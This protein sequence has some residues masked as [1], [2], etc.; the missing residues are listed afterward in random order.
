MQ[1]S[2]ITN[3]IDRIKYNLHE[4]FEEINANYDGNTEEFNKKYSEAYDTFFREINT[5]FPEP[6]DENIKRKLSELN[7]FIEKLKN[8]ESTLDYD[9]DGLIEDLKKLYRS[10]APASQLKSF[11]SSSS[12]PTR[13]EP[14]IEP[15]ESLEHK[16]NRVVSPSSS[17]NNSP[18]NIALAH[19]KQLNLLASER[20]PITENDARDYVKIG[21]KLVNIIGRERVFHDGAIALYRQNVQKYVLS[22]NLRD[23]S[24]SNAIVQST[25]SARQQEVTV[26]NPSNINYQL[27]SV[28]IPNTFPAIA[29]IG[30]SSNTSG[31]LMHNALKNATSHERK[32]I[33][34]AIRE[35]KR[36]YDGISKSLKPNDDVRGSILDFFKNNH[37]INADDYPVGQEFSRIATI[38]AALNDNIVSYVMSPNSK[39][40]EK[41]VDPF[42]RTAKTKTQDQRRLSDNLLNGKQNMTKEIFSPNKFAQVMSSKLPEELANEY[43]QYIQTIFPYISNEMKDVLNYLTFEYYAANPRRDKASKK[44][45]AKNIKSIINCLIE[46]ER[47]DTAIQIKS[48]I[49]ENAGLKRIFDSIASLLEGK[50][51]YDFNYTTVLSEFGKIV[52]DS[53]IL[54]RSIAANGSLNAAE[55]LDEDIQIIEEQKKHLI[56]IDFLSLLQEVAKELIK[57]S[58]K[59]EDIFNSKKQQLS[60]QI[61][62][63]SDRLNYD[64]QFTKLQTNKMIENYLNE[65]GGKIIELEC[66]NFE[67]QVLARKIEIYNEM[68]EGRAPSK[69]IKKLCEDSKQNLSD[70]IRRLESKKHQLMNDLS[71]ASA[72]LI[73]KVLK[74]PNEAEFDKLASELKIDLSE[75]VGTKNL[76]NDIFSSLF[77][78]TFDML[79]AGFNM[80]FENLKKGWGHTTRLGRAGLVG[81]GTA[82]VT[83]AFNPVAIGAGF[84]AGVGAQLATDTA[85]AAVEAARTRFQN[86]TVGELTNKYQ[87]DGYKLNAAIIALFE[88]RTRAEV[89]NTF[90]VQTLF[91]LESQLRGMSEVE[92]NKPENEILIEL[93]ERLEANYQSLKSG[94]DLTHETADKLFRSD[95]TQLL[96]QEYQWHAQNNTQ[97]IAETLARDSKIKEFVIQNPNSGLMLLSHSAVTPAI[98]YSQSAGEAVVSREIDSDLLEPEPSTAITLRS[99][100]SASPS[101]AIIPT[102]SARSLVL[103]YNSNESN[104]P[105]ERRARAELLSLDAKCEQTNQRIKETRS[106][107]NNYSDMLRL[108]DDPNINSIHTIEPDLYHRVVFDPTN[109][110][111]EYHI[112]NKSGFSG[113]SGLIYW[114]R[115][116]LFFFGNTKSKDELRSEASARLSVADGR[117]VWHLLADKGDNGCELFYTILAAQN[118]ATVATRR[119]N[120]ADYFDPNVEYQGMNPIAYALK[121]GNYNL[122]KAL[123]EQ[124][125]TCADYF[126]SDE[127]ERCFQNIIKSITDDDPLAKAEFKAISGELIGTQSA[128]ASWT[129]RLAP[130]AASFVSSSASPNT[131]SIQVMGALALYIG[132]NAKLPDDEAKI[133][134]FIN[135][136]RNPHSA[137]IHIDGIPAE[138]IRERAKSINNA[139]LQKTH[140]TRYLTATKALQGLSHIKQALIEADLSYEQQRIIVALI[141]NDIDEV[142]KI[143]DDP[144]TKY[145][146]STVIEL[147]A[148]GKINLLYLAAKLDRPE[149]AAKLYECGTPV[150]LCGPDELDTSK[151]VSALILAAREGNSQVVTDIL[152]STIKFNAAGYK[153][154]TVDSQGR[155]A[156]HYLAENKVDPTACLKWVQSEIYYKAKFKNFPKFCNIADNQSNTP[157]HLLVETGNID[158]IIEIDKWMREQKYPD[159]IAAIFSRPTNA[160]I[161]KN[162]QGLTPIEIALKNDDVKTF[163]FLL[164]LMIQTEHYKL[165][166][167]DIIDK[168]MEMDPESIQPF[169]KCYNEM[170]TE[171]LVKGYEIDD[172]NYLE[173]LT[174][175]TS[176]LHVTTSTNDEST[177]IPLLA[178]LDSLYEKSRGWYT[179]KGAVY[180]TLNENILYGL[181]NTKSPRL[182]EEILKEAVKMGGDFAMTVLVSLY[183]EATKGNRIACINFNRALQ[184]MQANKAIT[185]TMLEKHKIPN[186]LLEV[187]PEPGQ[188]ER[189]RSSLLLSN[190]LERESGTAASSSPSSPTSS[191]ERR[192]PSSG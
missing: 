42:V 49:N 7:D 101:Y 75:K 185:L 119:W 179:S 128:L 169:I 131:K 32:I 87:G 157:M 93:Q 127:I 68:L 6:H 34:D 102:S 103:A 144:K 166:E 44:A 136:V 148:F 5:C 47:Q 165:V 89:V 83:G 17:S 192:G 172:K 41:L 79:S 142:N 57:S 63:I 20:E 115:E 67:L 28:A 170:A 21:D 40:Y 145:I 140:L 178:C 82:A 181:L 81:A 147:K 59:K 39:E 26:F 60:N 116:K 64:K 13:V 61:E 12:G 15:L 114:F 72:N 100:T 113:D 117:S 123:M 104:S 25:P 163:D 92:R 129:S 171:A 118:D 154:R 35:T 130:R 73:K 177:A 182:C 159:G 77:T 186:A 106:R 162:H 160:F 105:E 109:M 125:L 78:G 86:M 50:G 45:D 175:F 191:P 19:L 66:C 74:T 58:T 153:R 155:T 141:R 16:F 95:F 173:Q 56:D 31:Y 150:E 124:M 62:E 121:I 38:I 37:K 76:E 132:Q 9:F 80:T 11:P 4:A 143:L 167:N 98:S 88:G 24:S 43:V 164:K 23:L 69:R 107:L 187:P 51:Y 111:L 91:A 97:Q 180:A 36:W 110:G 99:T 53:K 2:S 183:T 135:T 108:Y 139:N 190:S 158:A 46:Y 52:C 14:I 70:E 149:I 176:A 33:I 8:D 184:Y 90:Y 84:V 161:T 10:S 134:D 189:R 151:Y 71:L 94:T 138:N 168:L 54:E 30:A 120:L 22:F 48:V 122:A 18:Q 126:T 96:Q 133:E 152:T 188:P 55:S 146:A 174:K 85:A 3:P 27:I 137:Y 112:E 1:G 156:F 29:T 65:Y